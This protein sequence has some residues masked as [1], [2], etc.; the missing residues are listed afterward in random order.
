VGVD[1]RDEAATLVGMEIGVPRS[2]LPPCE[3]DTYY[4]VDLVG[5]T[6]RNAR[7]DMLGTVDRMLATGV[8]DVM[9]LDRE[10]QRMIPFV[11]NDIVQSVDLEK[12]VITVDWELSY[13][14]Q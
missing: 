13:W 3:D 8:H 9:V 1:D 7:G 11:R 4:W 2:A 14:D 10:G 6:V 12:G 5:L